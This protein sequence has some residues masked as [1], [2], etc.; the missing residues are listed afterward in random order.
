M[1]I[2]VRYT[3]DLIIYERFIGFINVSQKQ[4]ANALST[5]IINFLKQNKINASVVAQAY[6]GANVMAGKFNGVQQKIKNEY[7]YAIYTHCM[8]HRINL[9]VLYMCK[10][11][12][13]PT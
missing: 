1:T 5:E 11:V 8:A 2:C 4:D 3:K 6:D 13:V 7:P 10:L 12:K 9:V